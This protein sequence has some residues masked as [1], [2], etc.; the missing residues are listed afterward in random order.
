MKCNY[1]YLED[2]VQSLTLRKSA[3]NENLY[4]CNRIAVVGKKMIKII[5]NTII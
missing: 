2:R 5:V 3:I 4:V 1:M